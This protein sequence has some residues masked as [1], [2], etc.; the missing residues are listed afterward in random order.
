MIIRLVVDVVDV[1]GKTGVLLFGKEKMVHVKLKVNSQVNLDYL[2]YR[3]PPD[4]AG[5]LAVSSDT[6][7]KLLIAHC[8]ISDMPVMEP[9]GDNVVT[10]ALPVNQATQALANKW[11]YYS[12]ADCSALN[13]AISAVFDLDFT[14]Y[15]RKGEA[16]GIKKKDIVEAYI[17][18][19]RLFSADCFDALHKRVY[20]R[21]Q[22]TMEQL[23]RKLLRKAYYIDESIDYKG[24]L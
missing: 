19:R 8:R 22:D 20:R 3:Y 24:L 9:D 11:V 16:L 13:M 1:V 18:S 5:T 2:A 10:L 17:V 14:G 7:G 21:S 6:L 23:T 15:Y 12:A 4:A